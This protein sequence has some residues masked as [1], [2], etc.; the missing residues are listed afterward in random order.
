MQIAE[1]NFSLNKRAIQVLVYALREIKYK[2]ILLVHIRAL[3][4]KKNKKTYTI[5]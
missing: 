1:S 5:F 2:N 4:Y 3:L